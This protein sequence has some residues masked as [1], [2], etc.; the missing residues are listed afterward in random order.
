MNNN[1]DLLTQYKQT[2][3]INIRNQIVENNYKLIYHMM[4][5]FIISPS[6][7][8]DYFQAGILGLIKGIDKYIENDSYKKFSFCTIAAHY[9]RNAICIE[10]IQNL[11]LKVSRYTLQ[12]RNKLNKKFAGEKINL[13]EKEQRTIELHTD[14]QIKQILN[15]FR[16]AHENYSDLE[17]K[18][19]RYT[20]DNLEIQKIKQLDNIIDIRQHIAVELNKLKKRGIIRDIDI[21]IFNDYFLSNEYTIQEDLAK[22]Y[23]KTKQAIQQRLDLIL[24][25]FKRNKKLIALHKELM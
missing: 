18:N 6:L 17:T 10:Y 20:I 14:K 11:S 2:K 5:K 21:N 12:V 22:K 13:S 4:K 9:I 25:Y 8:E 3:D 15:I 1:N 7:R 19:S 23:N 16:D 24:R